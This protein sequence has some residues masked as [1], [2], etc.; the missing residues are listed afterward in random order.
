MQQTFWSW[1]KKITRILKI[2]NFAIWEGGRNIDNYLF[3]C[4][5]KRNNKQ[6]RFFFFNY[7]IKKISTLCSGR[8][9]KRGNFRKGR[10]RG[11]RENLNL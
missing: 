2:L 6:D 7:R 11:K 4:F 1:K 3:A 8:V 5:T 9:A 10:G